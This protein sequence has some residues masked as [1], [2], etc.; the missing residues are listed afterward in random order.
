MTRLPEA[1]VLAIIG[2]P[3]AYPQ[4]AAWRSVSPLVKSGPRQWAVTRHADVVRLLRD[5]RVGHHM[6]REYI[7]FLFGDT[8]FSDFRYHNI[9]NQ[10]PPDHTR[11]RRL[12]GQAFSRS[13]VA[14]MEGEV[15]AL[16][17]ELLAPALDGGAFDVASDLAFPLPAE[18]IC[19]I[20]GVAGVDRAE[21]GRRAADFGGEPDVAN[22]AVVWFRDL[23]EDI[24]AAKQ[25][26]PDG[27]LLQRMLAARDGDDRL[28]RR[29]IV[30]NAALLF[31]AGFETTQY[32][33]ASGMSNL[34]RQPAALERLLDDPSLAPNA[35][36]ELLRFDTFLQFVGVFVHEPVAIG[37]HEI[38]E[39][40]VL[41]LLLGSANRDEH[42]FANPDRLDIGRS[43]NPHVSFGGGL[44][45][46]LG[47]ALARLEGSALLARLASSVAS[48]QPAGPAM[49]RAGSRGFESVPV[50][51]VPKGRQAA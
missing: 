51:V 44:H 26:S 45:V 39:G 2:R 50:R 8:P 31:L 22:A 9:L 46:C 7:E 47:A 17:D 12:M 25:P 34:L 1:D 23:L 49:R 13:L 19:R 24:L 11:M 38:R 3:D 18:V 36:E 42:V 16:V 37:E 20:L 35:V 28:S 33:V 32:L 15:T 43:P 40:G 10:D 48:I 4:L 5:R 21:V 29:E 30:D 6:P 14:R 41:Y 27:D